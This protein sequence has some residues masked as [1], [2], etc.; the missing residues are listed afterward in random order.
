MY[1]FLLIHRLLEMNASIT[2]TAMTTN[3]AAAAVYTLTIALTVVRGAN[4]LFL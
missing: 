1:I 2:T 3:A 4:G